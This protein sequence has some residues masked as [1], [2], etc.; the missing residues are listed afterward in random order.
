M[1]MGISWEMVYS[2]RHRLLHTPDE[3][4][5][6]WRIY[7]SSTH[8]QISICGKQ[9]SYCWIMYFFSFS[10]PFYYVVPLFLF[11]DRASLSLSFSFIQ[12]HSPVHFSIFPT[13]HRYRQTWPTH[14]QIRTFR[15]SLAD[16]VSY[17]RFSNELIEWTVGCSC[18]CVC[19]AIR[20]HIISN[21]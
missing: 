10:F 19:G 11:V 13:K 16:S 17:R 6:W 12:I 3:M 5:C 20:L 9:N 4:V 18:V 21:E 8:R 1:R 14:C 7:K 15:S 2:D